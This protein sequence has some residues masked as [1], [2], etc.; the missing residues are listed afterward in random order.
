MNVISVLKEMQREEGVRSL[1]KLDIFTPYV[2]EFE[3][4]GKPLIYENLAGYQIEVPEVLEK[5]KEIEAN[6]SC[7]YAVTHEDLGFGE[8]YDFLIVSEYPEEWDCYIEDL[9][10]M[11]K[12][13]YAYV[14]NKSDEY[15]SEYGKIA[16][17]CIGGGIR[18]IK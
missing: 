9:G 13:A 8:L 17:D 10:S 2:E 11:V 18:R 15:R 4:N 12:T 3:I 1:R 5:I 7:V 16:L 6:G 14:W